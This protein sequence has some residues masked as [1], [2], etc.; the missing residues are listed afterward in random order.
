MRERL[1]TPLGLTHTITLPEEALLFGAAAGHVESEGEQITA[2]VWQLPRSLGPAGLI[3]A[4]VA[5]VL[6]FARMHLA[7]G[8][9]ADG[10][11]VLSES[12]AGQM[13]EHQADL[14]D[15]FILG[16]SWGLGWIRFGWNG[17]AL[18]GHDGNTIGQAGVPADL[19]EAGLAVTLLTNGSKT[20][21]LYE[22]L[23]REIFAELGRGDE[24]APTFAPPA[25]PVEVT[26]PYV[27]ATSGLGAHGGRGAGRPLLRTTITGPSA[28]MVPTGRRVPAGPGRPGAVRGAAAGGRDLGR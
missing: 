6:A 3:T 2:P 17:S 24:I 13:A 1:F 20:R 25:E 5:D 15:K 10:T 11:R 7:G 12:S 14:P 23:Y 4:T 26:W 8:L 27:G 19:P 21:D 18:I 9:A 28:E 16:D 22:D